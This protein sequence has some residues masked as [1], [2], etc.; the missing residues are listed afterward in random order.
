MV[1][2]SCSSWARTI[3]VQAPFSSPSLYNGFLNSHENIVSFSDY[4][5]N[6]LQKNSSQESQLF[7]LGDYFSQN[8]QETIQSVK[9]IQSESPLTLLSLRYIR[10]LSEKALLQKNLGNEKIELLHFYCK[11]SLLLNEGPILY[12]CNKQFVPLVALKKQ[13]PYITQVLL[14]TVPFGFEEKATVAVSAQTSY[15]WTLLSNTHAPIHFFGTFQQL[16]NQQ[17]PAEPLIQGDCEGFTY[18]DLDFEVVNE[19]IVFFSDTCQK[20]VQ[21][22]EDK[23]SWVSENKNLLITAGGLVAAGLL[24]NYMKGKKIVFGTSSFK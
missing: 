24:Y 22:F 5:K 12:P 4:I 13:Y 6:K 16:L 14:E 23:K 2:A 15:Q 3:L 17:L 18:Q 19:G 20:K 1:F 8:V 11:T 10:D 21:P 7:K 9:T